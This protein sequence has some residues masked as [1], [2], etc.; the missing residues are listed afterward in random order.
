VFSFQADF[1]GSL[2]AT[3]LGAPISTMA[4]TVSG[5]G[6]YLISGPGAIYAFGDASFLGNAG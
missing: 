2:G 3:P 6:Y 4:P 1:Y 5:N